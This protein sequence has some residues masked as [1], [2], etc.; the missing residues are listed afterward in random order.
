MDPVLLRLLLF[1]E[2]E[3]AVF[4]LEFEVVLEA[5]ILFFLVLGKMIL[6]LKM[7]EEVV[8]YF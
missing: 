6:I 7:V 2:V 4:A 3:E 8:V 5:E 1:H